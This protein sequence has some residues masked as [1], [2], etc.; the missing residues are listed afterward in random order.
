MICVDPISAHIPLIIG[1][2]LMDMSSWDNCEEELMEKMLEWRS[3]EIK[4]QI[5]QLLE[6]EKEE[7]MFDRED[8]GTV[9]K[10]S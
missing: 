5:F 10:N 8:K 6:A 9:L 2:L 3:L 4:E 1:F 7:R